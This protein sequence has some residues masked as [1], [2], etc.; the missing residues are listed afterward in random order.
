MKI[1][2]DYCDEP[3]FIEYICISNVIKGLLKIHSS[4]IVGVK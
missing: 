1:G 4:Y 2:V 3:I